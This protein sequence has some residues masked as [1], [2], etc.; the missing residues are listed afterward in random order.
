[1]STTFGYDIA[2]LIVLL[3]VSLQVLDDPDNTKI[4]VPPHIVENPSDDVK[5]EVTPRVVAPPV[6]A[7]PIENPSNNVKSDVPYVE[8]APLL[9]N[10][11]IDNQVQFTTTKRFHK[12]IN[13]INNL[14]NLAIIKTI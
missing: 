9:V 4:E 11:S 10:L 1:M 14:S 8:V 6:I 2:P 13:E 7:T 3:T 12:K 5:M